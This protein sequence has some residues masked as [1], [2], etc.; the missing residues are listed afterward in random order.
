MWFI[1]ENTSVGLCLVPF[2]KNFRSFWTKDQKWSRKKRNEG[3]GQSEN[4]KRETKREIKFRLVFFFAPSFFLF[5]N[6]CMYKQ[7]IIFFLLFYFCGI[8]KNFGWIRFSLEVIAKKQNER[9][10]EERSKI[11]R[12][13]RGR[14]CREQHSR[15]KYAKEKTNYFFFLSSSFHENKIRLAFAGWKRI[16]LRGRGIV[17]VLLCAGFD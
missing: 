15:N 5:L 4:W 12:G 16:I 17:C 10:R 14:T 6:L 8:W 11:G 2:E 9:Q 7:T 13:W 3:I 1:F